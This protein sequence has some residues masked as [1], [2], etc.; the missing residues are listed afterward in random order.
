MQQQSFQSKNF[1][2]QSYNQLNTDDNQANIQE[3]N[4]LDA[5]VK[6]ENNTDKQATNP[7]RSTKRIKFKI[8]LF[9]IIISAV[10]LSISLFVYFLFIQKDFIASD[11]LEYPKENF[12]AENANS[13]KDDSSKIIEKKVEQLA[14]DNIYDDELKDFVYSDDYQL[15][16]YEIPYGMELDSIIL[17]QDMSVYLEENKDFFSE[18]FGSD[19]LLYS[20]D[21]A[22]VDSI[23]GWVY[24]PNSQA[25]EEYVQSYKMSEEDIL[26][27]HLKL[28]IFAFKY[29]SR[30]ELN[31]GIA[32]IEQSDDNLFFMK[33]EDVLVTVGP[34]IGSI[35]AGNL[36]DIIYNLKNRLDLEIV[37]TTRFDS[38]RYIMGRDHKRASNLATIFRAIYDYYVNQQALPI[39]LVDNPVEICRTITTDCSGL[40]DLS[41]LLDNKMFFSMPLDPTEASEKGTGY[42]IAQDGIFI[43]ISAP[44]MEEDTY[45]GKVQLIVKFPKPTKI[46]FDDQIDEVKR[47]G[48]RFFLVKELYVNYDDHFSVKDIGGKPAYYYKE[49][50]SEDHD[51]LV[52]IYD[53]KEIGIGYDKISAPYY[54]AEQLT[55]WALK[56]DQQYLVFG[57]DII[58]M[59]AQYGAMID[60]INGE[61]GFCGDLDDNN[62]YYFKD[63]NKMAVTD[64]SWEIQRCDVI[65]VD[66]KLAYIKKQRND[67]NT[68]SHGVLMK[69]DKSIA[70]AAILFNLKNIDGNL[71]YSYV[72]GEKNRSTLLYK[73]K[74]IISDGIIQFI[75]DGKLVYTNPLLF[76]VE[77]N[78]ENYLIFMDFD[79]NLISQQ[80]MPGTENNEYGYVLGSLK[81]VDN[82]LAYKLRRQVTSKGKSI[83]YIYGGEEFGAEYS[84]ILSFDEIGGKLMYTAQ[85]FEDHNAKVYIVK[86]Q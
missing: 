3:T 8:L 64:G 54:I 41:F 56:G 14:V 47:E 17:E 83:K 21:S 74:K 20:Y 31:K 51:K 26:L 76:G 42:Y 18:L 15:R 62:Y 84:E 22:V 10:I 29:K 75:C 28:Y 49:G 53:G 13:T 59:E 72:V 24:A 33:G 7:E 85:N 1:V 52:V 9:T 78:S 86:E 68:G 39:D 73:D 48:G 67:N 81:C 65:G 35:F 23:S 4:Q 46:I 58:E 69:G 25:V 70:S 80:K 50:L 27:L 44:G 61:P 55:Y 5:V 32:N 63:G 82:K 2:S 36:F 38:A 37:Y 6:K 16:Q 57:D 66:G 77:A 60:D 11:D 45:S 34:P 30:D 40:I 12:I 43:A 19:N 79:G 71:A